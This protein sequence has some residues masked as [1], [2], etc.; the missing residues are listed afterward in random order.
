M[1]K[2]NP[3]ASPFV[4]LVDLRGITRHTDKVVT[5]VYITESP[6]SS[7]RCHWLCCGEPKIRIDRTSGLDTVKRYTLS[8]YLSGGATDCEHDS[9]HAFSLPL[10]ALEFDGLELG[11]VFFGAIVDPTDPDDFRVPDPGYNPMEHPDAEMCTTGPC[12]KDP[13]I[14]VPEHLYLPPINRKLFRKVAGKQVQI[15]FGTAHPSSNKD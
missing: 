12:A 15:T 13:H 10:L 4:E 11:R 14:I 2:E 8:A 7:T 3:E 9:A 5:S 6:W 1:S